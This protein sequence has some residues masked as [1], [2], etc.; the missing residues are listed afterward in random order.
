MYSIH[1]Y[2]GRYISVP[3]ALF[4]FLLLLDTGCR[5]SFL[6]MTPVPV[7]QQPASLELEYMIHTD[8]VDRRQ[9][10]V[11]ATFFPKNKKVATWMLRDQ[12]RLKR[13]K[14][15]YMADSLRTEDDR[16]NAGILF[17]HDGPN[18]RLEDTINYCYAATI[19]TGLSLTG[20]TQ[21]VKT[22]GM[23]Y[24]KIAEGHI[25]ELKKK[26]DFGPYQPIT[27]I[28]VHSR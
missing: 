21:I 12:S 23:I 26:Y 16:M 1:Q 5:N 3:G 8:Q 15:L 20:S 18:K 25:A 2:R 27:P 13:T 19:F 4:L 17:I 11:R 24:K 9:T 6:K 28:Q 7:L 14:E 10:L 22:N